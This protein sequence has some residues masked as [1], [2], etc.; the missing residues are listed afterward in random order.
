LECLTPSYRVGILFYNPNIEPAAEYIRRKAELDKLPECFEM[1]DCAY[2]NEVFASAVAGSRNEPEGGARCTVC[3]ELRLRESAKR[4]AAEG[5]DIFA[6]TLTVS[7]HKNAKIINMIG[8]DIAN[9]YG[10]GYL[11]SDFKKRDGYKRSV[12]LTKSYGLY[13]QNY[14]GCEYSRVTVKN[15]T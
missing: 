4:A 1:L 15:A 2:E 9:E 8:V 7:P 3:F 13:R 5:Y 14:C 6:T 12:E 10:I 11:N